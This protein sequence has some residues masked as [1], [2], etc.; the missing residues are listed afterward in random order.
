MK[1]LAL[2]SI[3]AMCALVLISGVTTATPRD[4]EEVAVA[5]EGL[6]MAMMLAGI[7]V[8]FVFFSLIAGV[9]IHLVPEYT[10]STNQYVRTDPIS[11][12]L[13]GFGTIIGVG[14]VSFGLI[15]TLIGAIF[16]IP[17]LLTLVFMSFVGTVI[18]EI[19]VGRYLL[20]EFAD[21]TEHPPTK[22]TLWLA[23]LVGF[24]ITMIATWIPVVGWIIGLAISSLGIGAMVQQFRKGSALSEDT[25]ADETWESSS[26]SSSWDDPESGNDAGWG[27]QGDEA[28]N[29]EPRDD[30]SGNNVSDDDASDDEGV[31]DKRDDDR[32]W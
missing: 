31:D 7:A 21:R 26:T 15:L 22:K 25:Q 17:M 10:R 27:Q 2:H 32:S 8:S 23:F 9:L 14:I 28:N 20:A 6:S 16:G 29:W 1:R 5:F 18:V 24:V 30:T 12:G 11:T 13:L 3:V 19:T 4:P